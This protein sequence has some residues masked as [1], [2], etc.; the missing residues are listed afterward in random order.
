MDLNTMFLRFSEK[1]ENGVMVSNHINYQSYDGQLE[2]KIQQIKYKLIV[3]I[4]NAKHIT[5][6]KIHVKVKVH[7]G[8][9]SRQRIHRTKSIKSKDYKRWD[10]MWKCSVSSGSYTNVTLSMW[11][12]SKGN[13]PCTLLG[14]MTFDLHQPMNDL[15]VTIADGHYYLLNR[16]LGAHKH[17][18]VIHR[19]CSL[20]SDH[21]QQRVSA[22]HVEQHRVTFQLC[23]PS[24]RVGMKL[25]GLTA[26]VISHISPHSP[27]ARVGLKTGDVIKDVNHYDVTNK[28]AT[29]VAELIR[30]HDLTKRLTFTVMRYYD[31]DLINDLLPRIRSYIGQSEDELD[32]SYYH[33]DYNE[34]REYD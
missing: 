12:R 27:A 15:N 14:Y 7:G 3:Q 20:E 17:L 32:I 11:N 1:S 24:E 18:K 28:S 31:N 5:G 19:S 2:L 26:A 34:M 25:C 10:D 23:S 13:T 21:T 16:S 29:T 9:S 22:A 33:S 30:G 8:Q 4:I 6:D